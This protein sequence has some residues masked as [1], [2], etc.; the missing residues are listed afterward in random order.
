MFGGTKT[1]IIIRD[2]V[3]IYNGP[4]QL[5][6]GPL[7][8]PDVS[9]LTQL[10]Q[11]AGQLASGSGGSAVA[12]QILGGISTPVP[13]ELT[14]LQLNAFLAQYSRIHN[15]ELGIMTPST[16]LTK[17]GFT[18]VFNRGSMDATYGNLIL[19]NPRAGITRSAEEEMAKFIE[20]LIQFIVF[21]SSKPNYLRARPLPGNDAEAQ[22]TPELAAPSSADGKAPSSQNSP[23]Q[24]PVAGMQTT[25]DDHPESVPEA[26]ERRMP[27]EFSSE[28]YAAALI[29]AMAGG[30]VAA[31]GGLALRQFGAFEEL[32]TPGF[33]PERME[34]SLPLSVPL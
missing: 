31:T 9:N 34:N 5:P 30:A 28:A 18:S 23:T 27:V 6:D 21:E 22:A 3:E 4:M 7:T 26:L 17:L 10:S 16:A 25:R 1:V 11:V 19:G 12:G 15:I 24:S 20:D 8:A 32:G 2:G 33:V 14:T 13:S 29:E